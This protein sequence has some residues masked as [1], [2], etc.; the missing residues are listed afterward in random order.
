MNLKKQHNNFNVVIE[1]NNL[2]KLIDI[3]IRNK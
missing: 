3:E 2:M 1:I